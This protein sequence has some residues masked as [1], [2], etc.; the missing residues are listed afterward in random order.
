[1][2]GGQKISEE[3]TLPDLKK[4]LLAEG[5]KG[6]YY[7]DVY[8]DYTQS[9]RRNG[10][11]ISMGAGVDIGINRALGFRLASVDYLHSWLSPLNG[12][13]FSGGVR[14]STGLIVNMGSW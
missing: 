10:L 14:F 12:V 7:R 1:M 11:A 8:L 3:K 4:E 9:F 5:V 2:V 6:T 13:D